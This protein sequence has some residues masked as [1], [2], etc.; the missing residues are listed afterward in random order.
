MENGW[1]VSDDDYDFDNSEW[2]SWL[3]Q[4][5]F[6][7]LFIVVEVMVVIIDVLFVFCY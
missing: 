4:F 5:F 7:D 2:V 6:V 1:D 3:F